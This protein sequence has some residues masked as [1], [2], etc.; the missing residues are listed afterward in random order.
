MKRILPHL[1]FGLLLGCAIIGCGGSSEPTVTNRS[2][3]EQYMI[4]HPEAAESATA[5]R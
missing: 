4:D 3:L 1:L 5:E 2:E